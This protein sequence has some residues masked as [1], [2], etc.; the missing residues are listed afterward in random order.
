MELQSKSLENWH[1]S[2]E[3]TRQHHATD[4]STQSRGA[5]HPSSAATSADPTACPKAP[6]DSRE[7]AG[8]NLG[9]TNPVAP[10]SSE[11]GTALIRA[12][13]GRRCPNT[14]IPAEADPSHGRVGP[15][16]GKDTASRPGETGRHAGGS[17]GGI[18]S[19]D[20]EAAPLLYDPAASGEAA[21]LPHLTSRAFAAPRAPG[22]RLGC[23][24]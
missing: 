4:G 10:L 8:R 16:Q 2:R 12:G 18:S 21:S 19:P 11:G 23:V 5:P 1:R 6:R 9:G 22:P 20:G 14:G 24:G 7:C 15:A 17:D 3:L 13:R